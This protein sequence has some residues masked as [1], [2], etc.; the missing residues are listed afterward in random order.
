[1]P[2]CIHVHSSS[3]AIKAFIVCLLITFLSAVFPLPALSYLPLSALPFISGEASKHERQRDEEQQQGGHEKREETRRNGEQAALSEMIYTQAH[4]HI[5]TQG[6]L[7]VRFCRGALWS[8]RLR[9][10][11]VWPPLSSPPG[12]VSCRS[13]KEPSSSLSS[14]A[15]VVPHQQE[16]STRRKGKKK[17]Q[18]H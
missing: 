12:L 7:F 14:W 11:N 4:A 9:L 6:P 15:P 13:K 3:H 18:R 2:K 17:I 5:H 1:M 10:M 16:I 8:R